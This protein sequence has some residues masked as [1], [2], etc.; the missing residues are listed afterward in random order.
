MASKREAYREKLDST[1]QEVRLLCL[2]PGTLDEQVRCEIKKVSLSQQPVYAALSY[3]WGDASDCRSIVL[4]EGTFTV[5]A[6]LEVALR[7]LQCIQDLPP[8]W[9]DAVCID[10]SNHI[11]K[12]EQ[13]RLMADI[14]SRDQTTYMWIG[15]PAQFSDVAMDSIRSI[16]KIPLEKWNNPRV[17]TVRKLIERPY[18]TRV[19]V[20]QVAFP[21]RRLL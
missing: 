14:Y 10:Q 6:N 19:W 3:V 18:W 4:G 9:V 20:I 2:F 16:K 5:T 21:Q 7:Y 13:I 1:H 12:E 8:L 15:E 17:L 11:E